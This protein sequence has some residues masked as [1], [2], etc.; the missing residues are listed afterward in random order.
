MHSM[1]KPKVYIVILNYKSWKDTIECLESV[2]KSTYKNVQILVVDNSPTNESI[3]SIIT[4]ADGSIDN[5]KTA[6]KELVYP[7]ENKPLEYRVLDE[8]ELYKNIH[9]ER[10]LVVKAIENKGFSA[11]NNIALKYIKDVSTKG[12]KVWLLNNDTVVCRDTLTRLIDRFNEV[13]N[14]G[15]LG[16]KLV[17][18]D[19]P[20]IIQAIG[21]KYNSWIGKISIVDNGETINKKYD[22][23]ISFDFPIGA[24]MF[25]NVD[26]IKE[27]GLME[28]R[29]FL[30][31][32]EYDWVLRGERKGYKSYFASKAIVYHKGGS[33]S[34]GSSSKLTDFYGIRSKL[35]FTQFFFPYKLPFLYISFIFFIINRVRRKQYDRIPMLFK[36]I[37]NPTK[38]YNEAYNK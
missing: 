16:A 21:G 18:Y 32:E 17:E 34:G 19:K 24:S 36:L 9:S 3:D 38:S 6:H 4:W 14:C 25:L 8:K 2:Y 37:L 5:I 20:D 13:Q 26:F 7:L 33:S 15:I 35:L 28:E 23:E 31:F 27:I 12:D 22:N 29:Y 11:G 10:L 30:Y 1:L